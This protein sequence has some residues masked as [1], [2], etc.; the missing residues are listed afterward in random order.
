MQRPYAFLK[1]PFRDSGPGAG[2]WP[3]CGKVNQE[4]SD[5]QVTQ[6]PVEHCLTGA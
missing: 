5:P 1:H 4:L 3:K 2:G 6:V